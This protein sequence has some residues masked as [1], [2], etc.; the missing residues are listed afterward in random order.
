MKELLPVLFQW[1]WAIAIAMNV[2]NLMI[3]WLRTGKYRREDPE[4]TPGYIHLC[5][6]FML[7]MSLP[8]LVM[9]IGCLSGSTSGLLDYILPQNNPY[10]YAFFAS[11]LLE[12]LLMVWWVFCR[13]GADFLIRHPGFFNIKTD[14]PQT[15]KLAAACVAVMGCIGLAILFFFD[16]RSI[17][18]V[19]ALTGDFPFPE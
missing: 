1:F 19:Q 8:W 3:M 15:I 6:H 13:N 17:L 2:F 9:G 16:F 12:I 5:F 18:S 11:I 4:R 7:W 10:V 14:N